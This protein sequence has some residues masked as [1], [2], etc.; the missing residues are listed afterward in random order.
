MKA[1]AEGS[2]NAEALDGAM[3]CVGA[4]ENSLQT[5]KLAAQYAAQ[6]KWLLVTYVAPAFKAPQGHVRS[7]AAWTAAQFANTVSKDPE[8]SQQVV[9]EVM[10]LLRDTDFAVRFTA[11]VSLR[12]LI[13]DSEQGEARASVLPIVQGVLPQLLDEL[14]KLMDEIGND[15]LVATLEVLIESFSEHMAPYAQGVSSICQC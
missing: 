4:L 7:R 2:G 12:H 5:G 8:F 11:A 14:F 9:N 1:F 10:G 6:V 13:Y 15:E 3:Y